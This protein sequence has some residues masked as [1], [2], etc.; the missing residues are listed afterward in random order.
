VQ[1]YGNV[2]DRVPEGANRKGISGQGRLSPRSGEP[3]A[4]KGARPVRWGVVG[5][6]QLTRRRAC[7]GYL[8]YGKP[9]AHSSWCAEHQQAQTLL[10]LG[11]QLGYPRTQLTRHRAIG[12]GRGSWEAYACRA[13]DSWLGHDLPFIRSTCPNREC[14]APIESEAAVQ[15]D[16]YEGMQEV[17]EWE[18]CDGWIEKRHPP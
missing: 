11:A 9:L 12:A 2:R 16:A 4:S 13:P 10:D 5:N 14:V 15:A 17:S 8:P 6:T 3:Y 7:A 18:E 1:D